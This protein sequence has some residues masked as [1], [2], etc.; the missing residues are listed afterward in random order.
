MSPNDAETVKLGTERGIYV[1]IGFSPDLLLK[2]E[3]REA[4][5]NWRNREVQKTAEQVDREILGRLST[6]V[7][8]D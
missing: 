7:G 8:T 4:M 5:Q 2:E 3:V 1:Q 6:H